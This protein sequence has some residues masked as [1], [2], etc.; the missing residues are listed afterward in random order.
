MTF[1]MDV[2]SVI[3]VPLH[4]FMK[5]CTLLTFVPWYFFA[6]AHRK[7]GMAKRLKAKSVTGKSEGPYRS[8]DHF[9]SLARMTFEK[10]DTLDKL[11]DHAVHCF[12]SA[13]CLGTRE[14]LSEENEK[15]P[16]GRVFKKVCRLWECLHANINVPFLLTIHHSVY[17]AILTAFY[18]NEIWQFYL[19]PMYHCSL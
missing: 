18:Y 17:K 6:D 5:L 2:P 12:G 1:K 11:F 19:S 8:L 16:N 9:E 14:V 15:Q 4:L 3:F 7:K 10:A 13:D